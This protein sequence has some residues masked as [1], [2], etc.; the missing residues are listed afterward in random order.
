MLL[1]LSLVLLAS[2]FS[3]S[4]FPVV[5]EEKKFNYS[6][7]YITGAAGVNHPTTRINTGA[8]GSF[9][10][11]TN[12]GASTELGFGVDLDGLRFEATYAIDASQLSGYT[13]VRGIDF[14]YIQGGE[15]RKQSAFLSGYWDILRNQSWTPYLG[16]GIG[17]TNLDVRNFSDPALSY[18]A[19]NRSLLG[20]QFKVG[21]SLDVSPD[22]QVFAEGVYR[23]TSRFKTNDG[24][25][26]WNNPSWSSWGGQFGVR[27]LL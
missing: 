1:R 4:V 9:E 17:Y 27:I 13:N 22:S 20:Y 25:D 6:Q 5:A 19:F 12:P 23:A 16:A 8:A 18:D 24:F 15:V 11:Y 10:E 26:D 2:G 14:D 7:L 3:L 21:F